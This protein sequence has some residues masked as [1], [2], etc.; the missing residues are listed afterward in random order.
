VEGECSAIVTGDRRDLLTIKHY[1]HIEI[2]QAREF[3][4]QMK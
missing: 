1:R 3:L 2:I 4:E